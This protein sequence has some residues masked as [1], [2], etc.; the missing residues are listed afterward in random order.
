M[1]RC[2]ALIVMLVAAILALLIPSVGSLAQSTADRDRVLAPH[3]PAHAGEP[4][5]W[6]A[7]HIGKSELVQ[8]LSDC[9]FALSLDPNDVLALSNRGSLYLIAKDPKAALADFERAIAL[10]SGVATL[11]FN[12]GVAHTD[13]GN[14]EA[15]IADY[16]EAIRLRPEFEAAFHNRGYEYEKLGHTKRAMADYEAALRIKP[17]LQPSMKRLEGLRRSL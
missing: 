11:H 12:R 4:G 17:D 8:A 1:A 6:C 5:T 16:T 2:G 15:A 3:D 10:K 13:L 9:T 7:V 14:A